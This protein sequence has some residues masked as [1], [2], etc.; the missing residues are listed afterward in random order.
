MTEKEHRQYLEAKILLFREELE[1]DSH[2]EMILPF[3]DK[4]FGIT[5]N[6]IGK[7]VQPERLSEEAIEENNCTKCGGSGEIDKHG[8]FYTCA[9]CN[10]TGEE[11]IQ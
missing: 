10:G 6:R 4:F 9:R 2:M 7:V 1:N 11:P 8:A 3:Y 5:K